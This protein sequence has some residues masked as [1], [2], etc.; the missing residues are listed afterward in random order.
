VSVVAPAANGSSAAPHAPGASL[1]RD[2]LLV[3]WYGNPHSA[4]MGVLGRLSGE[5]RAAGLRRQ[6]NAYGALTTKRVIAGYHLV[7][8][9]AQPA[10]GVDRKWRRR[11][12]FGVIQ[13]LL[14]EA[15]TN[16]FHLDSTFSPDAPASRSSTP[17]PFLAQ[18]GVHLALDPE[19][20]MS[21]GQ[22]PGTRARS[23]ACGGRGHRVSV[24][25]GNHRRLPPKV[26]MVHQFTLAMLPD[27]TRSSPARHRCRPRHGRLRL[28]VA[29]ALELPGGDAPAPAR[30]AGIKLFYTIDTGCSLPCR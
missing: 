1:L 7:A 23:H 19:F 8:V 29:E 30:F 25:A 16:G 5:Q 28:T 3:T 17:R 20:D 11:E 24:A 10:A 27:R 12:S 13:S 14:D 18:P 21:E 4:K 6:A 22:V 2:H 15:R 9:V 26:L